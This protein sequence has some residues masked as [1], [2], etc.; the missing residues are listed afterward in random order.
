MRLIRKAAWCALLAVLAS[1]APAARAQNPEMMAPEER[2]AKGKKI[3]ADLI[4]AMGGPAYLGMQERQCEGRRALI[5]HN[6]EL[7]GYVQFKDSWKFPDTNRIDYFSHSRNTLLGYMIGVQDLDITKGGMVITLFDGDKGWT[8]DKSGVSEMPET[9]VAEFDDALKS[10]T[11]NLLRNRLKEPGLDVTWAGRNTV[12]LRDCDMVEITD[13]EQRVIRLAVDRSTHL[14]VRS[15]SVVKD[16]ATRQ[17]RED[18]TIYTNYQ[19]EDGV[20]IPLQITRERDGRRIAQVFY[21]TCKSNPNLPADFFTQAAL[22][23]KFK[24]TGGKKAK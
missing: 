1:V 4:R 16:E 23:Q 15:I 6:G 3:L 5:G 7:A 19:P 12:D 2:A 13:S 21:S 8:M 9:L 22:E 11:D 18:T 17:E 20:Q 24:E 10:N 14:L